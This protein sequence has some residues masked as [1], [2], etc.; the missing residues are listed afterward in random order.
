MATGTPPAAGFPDAERLIAYFEGEYR[1][2]S[3]AKVGILSHAIRQ[4]STP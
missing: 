3:E 4:R 2:L 1:P